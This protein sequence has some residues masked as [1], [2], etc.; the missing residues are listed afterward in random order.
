METKRVAA[1][2]GV[3]LA[4][5]AAG[6]PDGREILFIHGFS[7]AALSWLRQM[8]DAAL[9]REFRMVAY[10]L[11]GHGGSDKPAAPEY[12]TEDRRWADD[13]AAVRAAFGLKRPVLVGWSYGGRPITDYIRHYGQDTVAGINFVA[14]NAKDDPSF[15]GE[16]Y[17]ITAAMQSDDF[18][19]ALAATRDFV[20]ACFEIQPTQDA[21]EMTLAFNMAVP[22]QVRKAMRTRTHNPG[23]LLAQFTVPVLVTHGAADRVSRLARSQYTAANVPG[24][25]LSTYEGVG[26]APFWEDAPRFN[27][28][29]AAFVRA[30]KA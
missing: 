8:E 7:Q 18:V 3:S 4:A 6:N 26:H 9:T 15:T 21:F 25:T 16:T 30:A 10:D 2:D 22:P 14:A 29:L 11:R 1:P 12:Y 13:I 19:T 24:A 17:T 5:Y 28:E 20:R 27:R 23:D